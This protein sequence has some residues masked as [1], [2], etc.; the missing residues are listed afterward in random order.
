MVAPVIPMYVCPYV[1]CAGLIN[2]DEQVRFTC[3]RMMKI[4]QGARK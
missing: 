2:Q 3:T 4:V 1:I